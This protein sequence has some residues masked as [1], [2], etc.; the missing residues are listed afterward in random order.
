MRE[1]L[2]NVS[3][4]LFICTGSKEKIVPHS[5]GYVLPR[6]ESLNTKSGSGL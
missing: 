3:L 1:Q 4:L 2:L 6:G 5:R